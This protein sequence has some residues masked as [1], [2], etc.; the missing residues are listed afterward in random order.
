VGCDT[1][2]SQQ[3]VADTQSIEFGVRVPPE[4]ARNAGV[5]SVQV[6]PPSVDSATAPLP[7]L[8]VPAAQQTEAETQEIE[9]NVT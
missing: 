9:L 4:S 2:A 6:F 1:P 5:F 3:V 8:S 7:V